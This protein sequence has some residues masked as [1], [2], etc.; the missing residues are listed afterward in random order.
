MN[1]EAADVAERL[2]PSLDGIDTHTVLQI[3]DVR[4]WR[5]W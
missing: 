5:N 3:Q 2:S 1:R 4:V